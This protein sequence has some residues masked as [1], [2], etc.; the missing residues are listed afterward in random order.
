MANNNNISLE[1]SL[2]AYKVMHT[3]TEFSW[4]QYWAKET[5]KNDELFKCSEEEQ[6]QFQARLDECTLTLMPNIKSTSGG[7]II[8]LKDLIDIITDPNNKNIK[9]TDRKV[10]Y[11]SDNGERPIGAQAFDMW[12]GFQVI[13]MDIKDE[14]YAKYFKRQIFERLKKYNWF[15]GIALSSSGKGLHIYTKIQIPESNKSDRQKNKILYL[16]NFRHKYSFVYLACLKIIEKN[17]K[18]SKEDILK[19]MDMSMFKPQ[20]GAFIGYDPNPLISTHFFQEFIYVNFDNVEDMGHPDV[21]WVTYPD[22]KEIFKRW[23]WFEDDSEYESTPVEVKDAPEL[24]VDTKNRYHYKHYERWRLANTL[25]RLYGAENGYNYLRMICTADIRNKELQS[26]C[27]TAAR[28]DK[29]IELWAVNRLNKYHGFKIKVNVDAEETDMSEIME[30][31]DYIEDPTALH[32]SKNLQTYYITKNEYLGNIKKQLLNSFGRITLIEAG[33]GT[34]K[35]E[36]VKEL[37]K[38]G[39]RVIMVMPFTSTIKSKIESDPDWYFSYGNRKV[40]FTDKPGLALTV[41]KFARLNLMEV[42]EADY[43][44]IFVDESHLLFQSEYRPVMPKVIELIRNTEVPVIMMSGTPI[45]EDIFFDNLVHL[46]VIKEDIR[47]KKFDVRISESP[48]DSLYLMCKHMAQDIAEHKRILFP[49]NKG[50]IYKEQIAALVKYFLET[51]HFIFEAPIINYYKKSNLGEDFMNDVNFK[52]TINK[53]DIL[54]CSTY[55]SVGVDIL[56]KFDFNIY[57]NEIWTPQEIEQFANRLRSHDLFVRLYLNYKDSDGLPLNLSKYTPCNLKLSDD[58]WKNA[59]SILRICNAMIERNPV[60][61]RYN[62]LISS[63]ISNN[64]YV[65]YNDVENKYYLNEI[66]YKTTYFERKFRVYAQQLPVLVKGML[67]YGYKYTSKNMGE[68][69][70]SEAQSLLEL[71]D[72]CKTAA[73]GQKSANTK[74][75]TELMDLITED[76]LSI[77]KE[78]MDGKYEIEKGDKWQE[79]AKTHKMTVKSIEMFEKVVPIFVSMSKMY[80]VDDIK[81][82]FEM[83]KNNKKHYNFAAIQRVR[84]LINMVYNAKKE[85]LDLPIKEFMDNTYKFVEDHTVGDEAKCKMNEINEF[86]YNFVQDYARKESTDEIIITMS[87]MTIEDMIKSMTKI[88]KCLVEV[89]RNT[90]GREVKIKLAKLLWV[91]RS[92]KEANREKEES[93]LYMLN[94]FLDA[95]KIDEEN[96]ELQGS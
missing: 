70:P 13:D 64:K 66:A 17:D 91:E 44:Y 31:V 8:T 95:M 89:G 67:S 18:L 79:D 50:T 63:I 4:K 32:V 74:H 15:L 2:L 45:G 92:V 71:E 73:E 40:K 19:W 72:Q 29:P 94:D 23:E 6:K 86:I 80:E 21:D 60:E 83:C 39:H 78:V 81:D 38:D 57:F 49:T 10:V 87:P 56:D 62:S 53:T 65:E 90:K 25:V 16:T 88:F 9:K 47:E 69:K 11:T 76:R 30:N 52:K 61:Y 12:G 68:F 42:K 55:L 5:F 7:R 1:K 84:L 24:E 48:K 58:E 82:I 59:Q 77:Y 3:P 34:G 46:K 93:K 35:T 51:D 85:R 54:M 22:L 14:Q 33:A 37:V 43:E 28:H 75:I 27:I 26:D 41:D 20:Q 96:I 36:M